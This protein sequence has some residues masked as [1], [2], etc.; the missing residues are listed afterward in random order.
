MESR[1]SRQVDQYSL[2][3]SIIIRCPKTI[4]SRKLS[5]GKYQSMVFPSFRAFTAI[6]VYLDIKLANGL[7][8]CF[9]CISSRMVEVRLKCMSNGVLIIESV[10][11]LSLDSSGKCKDHNQRTVQSKLASSQGHI[12]KHLQVWVALK[13]LMNPSDHIFRIKAFVIKKA[14]C[15]Y[16][17]NYYR[18]HLHRSCIVCADSWR[19]WSPCLQ[20]T[21]KIMSCKDARRMLRGTDPSTQAL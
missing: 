10:M 13:D 1:L 21:L 11:R 7:H 8:T 3:I 2:L 18:L 4:R 16:L 14:T 19:W 15:T 12:E 5:N 9:N 6:L 20:S 17:V